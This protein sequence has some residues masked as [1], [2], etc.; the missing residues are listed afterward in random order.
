[1]SS[2]M[3]QLVCLNVQWAEIWKMQKVEHVQVRWDMTD[4]MD[5]VWCDSRLKHG[6]CAGTEVCCVAV[7]TLHGRTAESCAPLY[8]TLPSHT[9]PPPE[10]ITDK[11]SVCAHSTALL[12]TD[13]S[14]SAS[15]W[16][17]NRQVFSVCAFYCSTSHWFLTQCLF[18]NLQQTS[19]QCVC[20]LL[21]Y[22][23]L[24]SH[25]APPPETTTDKCSVCAHSTALLHTAF[26]HS[27]SSWNYN[28][29]AFSVC[30]FYCSTSRWLLTQRLFLK[31]QQTSVQCVCILLLYFTLTSHTAPLPEIKTDKCSVSVHDTALLHT[32]FSQNTSS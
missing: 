9:A 26:S 16:N 27:A 7:R 6:R 32:D 21:L 22:F 28:R 1:M 17:Y 25:T 11:C 20:I 4:M 31:L 29:Q 5:A 14:H 8:S 30:A 10:T 18:L 15:S 19:V 13:F 12:H 3:I 2:H 23:T 24:I